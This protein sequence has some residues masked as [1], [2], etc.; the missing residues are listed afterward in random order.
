MKKTPARFGVLALVGFTQLCSYSCDQ[1]IM[2]I[3]TEIL[4]YYQA[5]NIQYNLFF[6]L[7]GFLMIVLCFFAGSLLHKN[8]LGIHKCLLISSSL[9]VVGNLMLATSAIQGIFGLAL[10]GRVIAGTGL[11]CQN[12]AIYAFIAIWFGQQ[13]HGLALGVSV[14]SIRF[15]SVFSSYLIPLIQNTWN[16]L[17]ISFGIMTGVAVLGLTSVIVISR[18]DAYNKRQVLS[19]LHRLDTLTQQYIE[20]H[21]THHDG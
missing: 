20:H 6:A 18:I 2:P 10:T 17:D 19:H 1:A 13:N 15:G 16:R 4:E 5:T 8:R 14:V 9:I 7:D 21:D 11:E 12:V 3:Q